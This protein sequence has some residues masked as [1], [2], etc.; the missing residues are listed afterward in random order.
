VAGDAGEDVLARERRASGEDLPINASILTTRQLGLDIGGATIVAGVDLEVP[1]GEF[2][3]IIG[4]NG[5]GK[6][7]LFNLLSGL[8]RPTSGRI[9]LQGR[10]VTHEP[11]H[12]RS[13]A[14][15]GRTF[16]I[17]SVFPRLSALENVR[18][19]A[20]A[21]LGGA[22][23]IWRRASGLRE[24]IDRAHW[25]L[26]RVGLGDREAVVAGSMP[27]GD[28]RKLELAMLLAADPSVILLDEPMAGVSSGDVP[29]LVEVIRAVHREEKKTVLMVE[30]H[31]AVVT[32]LADRIAV[33]H[34]GSLLACD[35]PERVME[36]E[37]VQSAYLGEPL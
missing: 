14:G 36:N 22:L 2:L 19:A 35:T 10:D 8:L 27:H 26:E 11:V 20:E 32:G 28:K 37:E 5:A 16:Q 9:E 4:P 30:H 31:M 13:R 17:S 25:A 6:T 29:G 1:P 15:L 12:L 21:S 34:H 33:M 18:L 23:R 3:G 24:A 7:S